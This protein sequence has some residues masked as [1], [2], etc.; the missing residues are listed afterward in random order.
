[1]KK[2]LALL[3]TF[4]LAISLVACGGEPAHEHVWQ[5]AT[6]QQANFC[7]ECGE[8]GEPLVGFFAQNGYTPAMEVGAAY[9]YRTICNQ[10]TDR[11][12]VGEI[13]IADYRIITGDDTYA[14]KEGYE[15]RIATFNIAFSD[16][17]AQAVGTRTRCGITDYYTGSMVGTASDDDRL[18]TIN[19]N[20]E[21]LLCD[22]ISTTHQAEWIDGTFYVSIEVG[23]QV[24][25]GYDGVVLA[26]YNAVRAKHNETGYLTQDNVLP[27]VVDEDTLFFRMD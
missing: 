13:T 3:L 23:V 20:G 19:Y 11:F 5:D 1:M 4:N 7:A 26:F 27:D 25:V 24:P 8:E 15:W 21:E 14:E 16:A 22:Y 17:N 18:L 10:D 9:N 6:Y 12:T 2:T